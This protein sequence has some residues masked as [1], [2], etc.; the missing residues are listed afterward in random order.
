MSTAII[1]ISRHGTT[2]KIANQ[3]KDLIEDSD[4]ID[5]HKKTNPDISKYDKLVIGCSIHMGQI[6]KKS[7]EFIEKNKD[8]LLQ[9]ELGLYLC[10][11]ETGEKAK[12][13]YDQA[14]SSELQ[15]HAK[16]N[17]ILGYE[18]LLEKMGFFEK[19]MVKK[20]TGK[21]KSFSNID[22]RGI[23]EFVSQFNI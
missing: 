5:L 2:E 11:M 10:C 14:F 3:M 13:Q 17:A 12:E 19:I 22:E 15:K 18:Y 8:N 7:K 9:K 20:I 4:L 1:Y 16:A 6:H 21:D 23:A